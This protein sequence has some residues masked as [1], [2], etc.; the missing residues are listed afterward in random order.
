MSTLI[1]G[2]SVSQ[3]TVIV[4]RRV[5]LYNEHLMCECGGEYIATQMKVS[6][7]PNQHHHACNGCGKAMMV[8][9]AYP[10]T[11]PEEVEE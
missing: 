6:A 10:R 9:I 1:N 4:K 8:N 3:Q 2:E 11:V 7:Y 5:N